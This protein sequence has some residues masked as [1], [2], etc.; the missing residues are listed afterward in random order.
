MHR[1]LEERTPETFARAY[2]H[3][4]LVIEGILAQTGYYGMQRSFRADEFPELPHLPGL[5]TG[6]PRIRQDERRHVGFGMAK[7]KGLV[8]ERVSTRNCLMTP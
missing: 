7:L 5:H 3:Y 8:A 6:F 1:L 4:H 2:T